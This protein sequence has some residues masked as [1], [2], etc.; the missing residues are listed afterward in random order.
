[1]GCAVSGRVFPL[2]KSARRSGQASDLSRPGSRKTFSGRS[3]DPKNR[4]RLH[5]G[6]QCGAGFQTRRL[7]AETGFGGRHG[8]NAGLSGL[9]AQNA[10]SVVSELEASASKRA[11]LKPVRKCCSR[12]KLSDL[13]SCPAGVRAQAIA[14]DGKIIDDFLLIQSERCLHVGNAP[15]PAATSAIPITHRIAE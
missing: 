8:R 1:M 15:S 4:W 6:A 7:Q 14:P 3:L 5:G 10:G 11:Y 13:T 12:I 9:L 2:D